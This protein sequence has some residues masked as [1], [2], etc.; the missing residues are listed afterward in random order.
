[1]AE[2]AMPG[3]GL[4]REPASELGSRRCC[5]DCAGV[6]RTPYLRLEFHQA[7]CHGEP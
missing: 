6:F 7:E 3:E 5:I 1:M 2:T 4:L